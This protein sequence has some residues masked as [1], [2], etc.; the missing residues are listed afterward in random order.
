MVDRK[1]LNVMRTTITAHKRCIGRD[2]RTESFEGKA[3]V[4]VE[5]NEPRPRIFNGQHTYARR[6][7]GHAL[8]HLTPSVGNKYLAVR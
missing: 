6:V 3:K 7:M 1:C 5:G 8:K 4:I 2:Y